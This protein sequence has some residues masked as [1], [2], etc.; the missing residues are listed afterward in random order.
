M[1][2][3]GLGAASA[4]DFLPQ[5][6]T[7][8]WAG[9]PGTPQGQTPIT[10]T[11]NQWAVPQAMQTQ[12]EKII[13]NYE[14]HFRDEPNIFMTYFT[15]FTLTVVLRVVETL[16]ISFI[17]FLFDHNC[18]QFLSIYLFLDWIPLISIILASYDMIGEF[19]WEK[20]QKGKHNLWGILCAAIA[21]SL[22]SFNILNTALTDNFF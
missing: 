19:C 21:T 3:T 12:A 18:Y 15:L 10:R 5:T 13:I 9:P 6:T 17:L 1:G 7:S 22:E 8:D 14:W 16:W 11:A 4:A 20:A 2:R